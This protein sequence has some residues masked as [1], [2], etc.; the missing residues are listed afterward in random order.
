MQLPEEVITL[1]RGQVSILYEA[2]ELC[3]RLP[4]LDPEATPRFQ[5]STRLT[6]F[7]TPRGARPPRAG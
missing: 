1:P 4:V 2:N 7:A 5:S 6:S 3:N